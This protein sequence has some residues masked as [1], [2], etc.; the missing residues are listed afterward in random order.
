MHDSKDRSVAFTLEL[1]F[2]ISRHILL[3]VAILDI[4][5]KNPLKYVFLS[6]IRL[7]VCIMFLPAQISHTH[8]YKTP[9]I[10]SVIFVIPQILSIPLHFPPCHQFQKKLETFDN[11]KLSNLTTFESL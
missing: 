4:E 10:I 3:F 9:I 5:N 1:N 2:K 8:P 6:Y 7:V 11:Q